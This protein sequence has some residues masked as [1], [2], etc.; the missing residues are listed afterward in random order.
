MRRLLF[1]ARLP[2][3]LIFV[4]QLDVLFPFGSEIITLDDVDEVGIVGAH[5]CFGIR[6]QSSVPV[7]YGRVFLELFPQPE[8]HFVWD[9]SAQRSDLLYFIE[10]LNRRI[11]VTIPGG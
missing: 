2:E 7:R 4:L 1:S 8:S 11:V 6:R 9:I 10:V 3:A 5:M